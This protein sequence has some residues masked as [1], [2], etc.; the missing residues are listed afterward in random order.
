MINQIWHD[1]IHKIKEFVGNTQTPL[2]YV[3]QEIIEMIY[4][5]AKEKQ[6]KIEHIIPVL[7]G[8]YTKILIV[9]ID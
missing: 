1:E 8:D 5:W 6:V 3:I 9:Y 2:F 7:V 4:D